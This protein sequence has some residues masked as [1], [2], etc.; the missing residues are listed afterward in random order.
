MFKIYKI[1]ILSFLF[2]FSFPVSSHVQHYK[3]LKRIEFD[4]YRNETHIGSHIFSFE[5]DKGLLSVK[6]LMHFS[7]KKFDITLYEYKSEGV[8]VY[9][10]NQLI[11]FNSSTNQNGKL[12]YVNI[13]FRNNKYYIQGSS[14]KGAVPTDYLIGS[15]W[16]HSLIGAKAQISVTSG[17]IIKQKVKFLGKETI[18]FNG[19][20]HNTL[21]YKFSSDDEKLSKDKKLDID[22][23]YD[24]K[25]L[26]WMKASFQKTGRWDY[27][28]KY[29]K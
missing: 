23:W 5:K 28:L 21:R 20:K 1:T 6:S 3:D 8:E 18:E 4:I 15:W 13:E 12:K 14:H 10:D 16:N 7:I 26:N 2:L 17:R 25:T 11:K 29:I 22:I 19:K 9:K 27:K 24:E